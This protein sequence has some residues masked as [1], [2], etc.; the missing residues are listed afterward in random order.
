MCFCR[1]I[2]LAQKNGQRTLFFLGLSKK[3]KETRFADIT[4]VLPLFYFFSSRVSI[5]VLF[6]SVFLFLRKFIQLMSH[7]SFLS[8]TGQKSFILFYFYILIFF[9]FG[10]GNIWQSVFLEK[11]IKGVAQ[12]FRFIMFLSLQFQKPV[13]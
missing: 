8:T 7:G 13:K 6:F 2:I 3:K 11:E 10:G 9:F 5:R 12:Y 4:Q 1:S